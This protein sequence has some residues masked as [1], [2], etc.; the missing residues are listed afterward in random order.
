MS[1]LIKLDDNIWISDGEAVSFYGIAYTTRMTIVKLKDGK[2]W[3]HSPGKIIEEMIDEV[4]SLGQVSYLVSPNKIHHLF[5]SDWIKIFPDAI[6]YSSPGLTEKRKD[7]SFDKNLSDDPEQEWEMEIDQVI[8]RGSSV[9]EEVVFFHKESKILILTDLIENFH[10]NYFSGYKKVIAKLTGIISPNGKAP[11]DWR[12]SFL[13]G[14][15]EARKSLAKIISWKPEKIVISHGE[16]IYSNATE[17]L[18]KSFKWVGLN[19][20][21]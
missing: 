21:E 16:C 12:V 5:M 6:S 14:K 11:L 10:H 2:L 15:S 9:M 13:F 3:V 4:K 20:V 19:K 18:L 8:F 7:I 17:F 1:F